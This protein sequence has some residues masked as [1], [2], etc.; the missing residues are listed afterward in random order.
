MLCALSSCSYVATKHA[1][2]RPK[3]RERG[4]GISGTRGE[5]GSEAKGTRKG[6]KKPTFI[7]LRA[8]PPRVKYGR[9]KEKER[10]GEGGPE[11][12]IKKDIAPF[13][14]SCTR[15]FLRQVTPLAP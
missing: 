4:I 14:F 10:S 1:S 12:C 6:G 3:T 8:F 15:V 5:G 7:S 11:E 2:G 9:E 13:I